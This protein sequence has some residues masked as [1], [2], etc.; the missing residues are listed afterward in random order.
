[1]NPSSST[2]NEILDV[3]RHDEQNVRGVTATLMRFELLDIF[4]EIG[5]LF[6]LLS[7][8]PIKSKMAVSLD[9]LALEQK[10]PGSDVSSYTAL[11]RLHM[12][13]SANIQLVHAAGHLFRGH[14]TDAFS[15]TRRAIEA[16][17]IAYLS[18]QEPD[19]GKIYFEDDRAKFKKMTGTNKILPLDNP[20][21]A[22]LHK[23]CDFGSLQMHNNLKSLVNSVQQNFTVS[24]EGWKLRFDISF[25][26]ID[27]D[28]GKFLRRALRLLRI[29]ER[30]LVL[31]AA[32][33]DISDAN[34]QRQINLFRGKVDEAYT[35][36][37]PIIR[38]ENNDEN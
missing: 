7:S 10:Q 37:D 12:Y 38:I 36:L 22:D 8:I 3:L 30:I 15:H 31:F 5:V 14:L 20:L 17:G 27:G 35:K 28:D 33:F 1:M 34:W 19:L 32:S 29:A 24:D 9:Q 2:P 4:G 18:T 21:T 11:L 23:D 6:N 26:E 16:A 13:S 25:H